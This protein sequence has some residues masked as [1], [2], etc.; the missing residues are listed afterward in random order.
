L[1]AQ[2]KKDRSKLDAMSRPRGAKQREEDSLPDE[3]IA[4]GATGDWTKA[5]L[6]AI[7]G[8]YFAMLE[9]EI[10]GLIFSKTEHRNALRSFVH[11]SPGA[12]ERK[13]QNISAVLHDLGLPWINGYKPLGNYQAALLQEI[14]EQLPNI[15][16]RLDEVSPRP[17]QAPISTVFVAPPRPI[18]SGKTRQL[19]PLIRKFD[20][21]ERDARNRMLGA[22]GEEYVLWI[23]RERLH[24]LGRSELAG[25]LTWVS[26]AVGDGLGYDIES[27]AEDGSPIFI[28][29]KTT[30]GPIDTPFYITE[31]E[32]RTA[33]NKGKSYWL[34][35][36]FSFGTE[37]RIYTVC[38]QLEDVFALEP[39]SYRVRVRSP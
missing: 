14:A 36:V 12:I 19:F 13:H 29:V 1:P 8:D 22:A 33:A 10:T 30:R 24:A 4:Q 23:E 16:S 32:R 25:K 39:V 38:G 9:S 6:Q 3:Q 20:P 34:Y 18:P 7:V 15:I 31:N 35:R 21:A 5:E 26:R 27:F 2:G 17:S 11:R 28:E 37:P